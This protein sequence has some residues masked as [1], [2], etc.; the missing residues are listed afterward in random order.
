MDLHPKSSATNTSRHVQR[1]RQSSLRIT[2]L[3]VLQQVVKSQTAK[4][5]RRRKMTRIQQL[6][7]IANEIEGRFPKSAAAIDDMIPVL[8]EKDPR[9]PRIVCLCGS[10]RF[11]GEFAVQAWELEKKGM[12]ALSIHLLPGWYG[13]QA[14]HQA[15]VEGVAEAMDELHKRKI[16]LADE[17]V[18]LNIGGY[19]GESTRSEINY[20]TKT[21]KPIHYLVPNDEEPSAEEESLSP[22]TQLGSANE[23]DQQKAKQKGWEAVKDGKE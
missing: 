10:S 7:A 20:A 9:R 16:D 21:G 3:R 14:D 2:S 11:V 18:I 23:A 17:V 4:G 6:K 19:I 1:D 12:I 22:A 8:T 13:G 15:E 5:L